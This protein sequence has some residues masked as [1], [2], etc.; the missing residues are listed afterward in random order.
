MRALIILM[1]ENFRGEEFR[2]PKEKLES[3]GVEVTVVGLEPGECKGMLGMRY[4]PEIL[5]DSV[6]AD[7]FD[8]IIVPGGA[9][10]PR[11]LWNNSNVQQLVRDAH[12]K[13]KIVAT[14]CL[15][16]AMFANAGILE[17]KNATVFPDNKAIEILKEKGANYLAE[18]VVVDGNIVTAVGPAAADRFADEILEKLGSL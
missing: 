4:T 6:K 9:G 12:E 10:S 18:D 3:N 2:V 13:G 7:D 14:I 15:A 5:I 11:Y 16:T 8:A 1:P 17:G